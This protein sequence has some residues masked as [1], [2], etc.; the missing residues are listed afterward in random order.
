MAS[1]PEAAQAPPLAEA[2]SS[3]PDV[4]QPPRSPSPFG[5]L[6]NNALACS[7]SD[8][9]RSLQERRQKLGLPNPGTVENVA[10]GMDFSRGVRVVEHG[11]SGIWCCYLR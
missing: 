1:V 9:Y 10:K 11:S 6:T 2:D 5:F 7:L 8:A 3:L 4:P